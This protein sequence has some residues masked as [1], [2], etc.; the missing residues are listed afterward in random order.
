MFFA[1]FHQET[2]R[3][4]IGTRG[5]KSRFGHS[6]G[7]A[8]EYDGLKRFKGQPPAHLL[9]RLNLSDPA[10]GINLPGV[11][12]LP[13]LCAIRYGACDLGYRI[14]SDSSVKILYQ[15]ETKAWDGFPYDDYP[16]KLAER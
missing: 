11:Q 13:L 16:G 1:V 5:K 7:G 10:V 6:F 14:L 4:F 12:W 8:A 2:R 9:F 15:R 3:I